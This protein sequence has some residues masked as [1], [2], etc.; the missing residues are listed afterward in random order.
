MPAPAPQN[1]VP[2]EMAGQE[3]TFD[4]FA[5]MPPQPPAQNTSPSET[6]VPMSPDFNEFSPQSMV[7]EASIPRPTAKGPVPQALPPPPTKQSVKAA[8]RQKISQGVLPKVTSP[9]QPT[10]PT[11]PTSPT[12]QPVPSNGKNTTSKSFPHTPVHAHVQL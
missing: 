5:Q 11:L 1:S 4:P 2:Q 7:L 9:T 10:Q 6:A 8:N 3:L 12:S